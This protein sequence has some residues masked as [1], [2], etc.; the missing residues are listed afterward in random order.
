MRDRTSGGAPFRAGLAALVLVLAAVAGRPASAQEIPICT[1]LGQCLALVAARDMCDGNCFEKIL[2]EREIEAAVLAIGAPAIPGLIEFLGSENFPVSSLAG[3]ILADIDGLRADH[4]P[5]LIEAS[6]RNPSLAAAAISRIGAPEAIEYMVRQLW[7]NPAREG[8]FASGLARRGGTTVPFLLERFTCDP[9][10]NDAYFKA[11]AHVLAAIGEEA[12]SAIPPLAAIVVDESSPF[13]LR[14]GAI[15]ALGAAGRGTRDAALPLQ[16][17]IAIA[18][19][20]DQSVALRNSAIGALGVMSRAGRT[21][22]PALR[23]LADGERADLAHA[24]ALAIEAIGDAA[25]V[26]YMLARLE[27]ATG[28]DREAAVLAFARLG[29]SAKDAAPVLRQLLD[30]ADWEARVQAAETLGWIGDR[31]AIPALMAASGDADWKLAYAAA[32]SLG[33]LEAEEARARLT[34]IAHSHWFPFVRQSAMAA[35]AQLDASAIGPEQPPDAGTIY[36]RHDAFLASL[37]DCRLGLLQYNGKWLDIPAL[38]WRESFSY[39]LPENQGI[40]IAIDHGERGGRLIHRD[41][42][43]TEL[44]IYRDNIFDIVDTRRGL[45]AVVGSAHMTVTQGNLLRITSSSKGAWTA[46]RLTR[47]PGTPFRSEVTAN[48]DLLL[49]GVN[50]A[51]ALNAD[52]SLEWLPC[53]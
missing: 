6:R 51:V 5:L 10:C 53:R 43:G 20:E 25:A 49:M 21:A 46:E 18:Q 48:G 45:I 19:D 40:L 35:L 30:S 7:I 1:E 4:L 39:E 16:T 32:D 41:A 23:E 42:N 37:S 52:S 12:A 15:V 36:R 26:P 2:E 11:A 29:S 47:L 28:V 3:S 9:V 13:S 31:E 22:V 17:L 14:N 27:R 8:A 38:Y 33:R 24:A 44:E 34:E 50:W